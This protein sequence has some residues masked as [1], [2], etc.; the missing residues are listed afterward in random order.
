MVWSFVTVALLA[1]SPEFQLGLADGTQVRGS[2]ETAT[3]QSLVLLTN[4]G[5]REIPASQLLTVAPA[6]ASEY[7][8]DAATIWIDLIDGSQLWAVGF[9]V[10]DGNA[11]I[12]FGGDLSITLPLAAIRSVRLKEQPEA[13]AKQWEAVLKQTPKADLI[14][15]R[16][17]NAIDYLEGLFGTVTNETVEFELDGDKIPVKR[18]KVEGLVYYHAKQTAL[19]PGICTVT[20]RAGSRIQVSAMT[21]AEG[22]LRLTTP[23]GA[24]LPLPLERV[25]TIAFPAR[26]LSDFKPEHILFE[27]RLREPRGVAQRINQRYQPRFDRALEAGPMRLAGREYAKGIALHSRSEITWLLPEPFV[28]FSAVAGIDD[29][30]RP[31]GNV[32]L[33]IHGDDRVLL[34]QTLHGTD[35]PLPISLDL[36][37]VTRLKITVDF[38][39][40]GI[41]TGDYLDLCDPRLYK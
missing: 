21:L 38:G 7:F 18:S 39:D 6:A 26:Y 3:A 37:G 5:R 22:K 28:K 2:L 4:T 34:E 13:I 9:T 20:D 16:E 35:A 8:V 10:A 25:S 36:T 14:V 40:D 29:R 17:E 24:M 1:A 15:I 30:V 27:T 23:A 41:E 12:S 31:H 19:P 32:R 11:A 33:T